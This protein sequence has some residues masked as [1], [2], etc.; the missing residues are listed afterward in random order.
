M[1]SD[2]A[3]AVDPFAA[4]LSD[5]KSLA[6]AGASEDAFSLLQEGLGAATDAFGADSVIHFL[7]LNAMARTAFDSDDIETAQAVHLQ[8]LRILDLNGMEGSEEYVVVLS[9]LAECSLRLED[10]AKAEETLVRCIGMYRQHPEL[11]PAGHA[12]AFRQLG[13][14]YKVQGKVSEALEALETACTIYEQSGLEGAAKAFLLS[15]YALFEQEEYEKAY[16]RLQQALDIRCREDGEYSIGA[17]EVRSVLAEVCLLLGYFGEAELANAKNAMTLQKLSAGGSVLMSQVHRLQA[18]IYMADGRETLAQGEL[19][20]ALAIVQPELGDDHPLTAAILADLAH[21]RE[22]M[23]EPVVP[24]SP[25]PTQRR[26][27][28]SGMKGIFRGRG[29][30]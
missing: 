7:I 22:V 16:P 10:Y 12:N 4:L 8:A 28:F 17:Y 18:R 19:E 26:S 20:K 14:L 3:S 5:A 1:P 11:A 2:D 9:N 30:M 25:A 23:P 27:L 15:G 29:K 6:A 21:V 13:D 24:G